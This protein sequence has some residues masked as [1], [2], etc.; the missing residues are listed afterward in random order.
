MQIHI[1]L[2]KDENF[3]MITNHSEKSEK[4]QYLKKNLT[5]RKNKNDTKNKPLAIVQHKPIV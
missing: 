5:P 2:V 4:W 3:Q 1:S